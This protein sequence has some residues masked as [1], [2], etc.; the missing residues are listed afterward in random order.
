[1]LLIELKA[2]KL[3]DLIL[4]DKIND[5]TVIEEDDVPIVEDYFRLVSKIL[6]QL[7]TE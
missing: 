3:A 7:S 2:I 1:M 4:C 5:K 6:L